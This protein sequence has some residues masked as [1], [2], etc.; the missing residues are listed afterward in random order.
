MYMLS[1][2]RYLTFEPNSSTPK[3]DALTCSRFLFSQHRT[4]CG[5]YEALASI[6]ALAFVGLWGGQGRK[7]LFTDF[8][9]GRGLR[10][11]NIF[12][13]LDAY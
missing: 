10:G 11:C 7:V 6:S 4:S 8:L 12:K 5:K 3:Y 1:S 2:Y 13:G 9:F